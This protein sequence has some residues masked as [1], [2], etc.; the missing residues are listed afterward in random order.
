MS[1]AD[2]MLDVPPFTGMAL[3]RASIKRKDPDWVRRQLTDPAARAVVAGHDGVVMRDGDPPA[4]LRTS[5]RADGEPI[6]LGLEGGAARF[7]LR[8]DAGRAADRAAAIDGA[9]VVPLRD[10]GA[11]LPRA[12]AGLAA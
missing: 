9:D 3:D 12:E 10:A 4:L 6:L 11:L 5:L 1:A 7:P 8:P 2:D